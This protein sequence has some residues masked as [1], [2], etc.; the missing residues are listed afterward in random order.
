MWQLNVPP[1]LQVSI[2]LNFI[3]VPKKFQD[4]VCYHFHMQVLDVT[5]FYDL[6]DEARVTEFGLKAMWKSPNGTIRNILN[7]KK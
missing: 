3:V 5:I 4:Y 6:T 1:L 2:F 7:G